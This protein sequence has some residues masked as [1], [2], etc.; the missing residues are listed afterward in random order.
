MLGQFL[1]ASL[2]A[3]KVKIDLDRAC[4]PNP[5][6]LLAKQQLAGRIDV[7]KSE[8]RPYARRLRAEIAEGFIYRRAI[9]GPAADLRNV[10]QKGRVTL[11]CRFVR[12]RILDAVLR[13]DPAE[14]C[15]KVFRA[16]RR[17]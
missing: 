12:D 4:H 10:R 1:A 3:G 11:S 6:Y 15:D 2:A 9:Q 16:G 5:A 17:H 7:D 14:F 8:V 13:K